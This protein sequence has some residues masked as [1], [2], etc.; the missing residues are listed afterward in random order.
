MIASFV[1]SPSTGV[2]LRGNR[3]DA[4]D[5]GFDN[6]QERCGAGS[7]TKALDWIASMSTPTRAIPHLLLENIM[8]LA[9][10]HLEPR[11][12]DNS[13]NLRMKRKVRNGSEYMSNPKKEQFCISNRF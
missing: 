8:I 6:L 3:A 2:D 12:I 13:R 1:S 11:L 9:S 10:L 7:R 5:I 4:D